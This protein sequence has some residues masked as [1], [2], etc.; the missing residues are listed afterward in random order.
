MWAHVPLL[1]A[2]LALATAFLFGL[3]R[4]GKP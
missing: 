4:P 1:N 3:V 2:A